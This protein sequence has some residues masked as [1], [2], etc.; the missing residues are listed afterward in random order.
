MKRRPEPIP[1]RAAGPFLCGGRAQ[2]HACGGQ[3]IFKR[4]CCASAR[5]GYDDPLFRFFFGDQLPREQPASS[6]GSG[7]IVSSEGYILTNEHVINSADEIEVAL[8]DGRT[9]SA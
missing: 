3:Y 7:V 8:A 2:G 4:V 9:A 1:P 5:P 6:P